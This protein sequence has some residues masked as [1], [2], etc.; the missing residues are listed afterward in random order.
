[1]VAP[2][3]EEIE[4][5]L[6]GQWPANL[7]E[8]AIWK[9]VGDSLA[10]GHLLVDLERHTLDRILP[11]VL[12]PPDAAPLVPRPL[13]D[14]LL[15]DPVAVEPPAVSPSSGTKEAFP[16]IDASALPEPLRE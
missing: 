13:P 11:L 1:M 5:R 12:L 16:T 9:L 10:S 2:A 3:V 7:V 6:A 14:T 8:A 4:S 15:L